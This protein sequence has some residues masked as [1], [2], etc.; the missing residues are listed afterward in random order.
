MTDLREWDGMGWRDGRA[1]NRRRRRELDDLG[2]QRTA[3]VRARARTPVVAA[4][5]AL[6]ARC[7]AASGG[8]RAASD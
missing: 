7:L 2:I 1:A 5:V 6:R 8:G 3:E 4:V